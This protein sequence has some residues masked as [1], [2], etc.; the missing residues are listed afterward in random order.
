VFTYLLVNLLSVFIPFVASFD[1]RLRFDREWRYFI[2]AMLLTLAF[3]IVWD[4]WFT[5]MG[6]WGFNPVYL[7]GI[8]LINL[9]IEEWMFFIAIPYACVFTYHALKY[10]I[11]KDVLGKAAP[12]IT[13]A[14]N[15]ALAAVL[16]FAPLKWYTSLTFLLTM[17]ALLIVLWRREVWLGRF[18]LHFFIILIPFF[19]VNGILTGSW[20]SDQVVWYNDAENLGFRLGTIPVEDSVYALLLLLMNVGFYEYFKAQKIAWFSKKPQLGDRLPDS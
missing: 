18:Y 4:V 1:R 16:V 2:P 12:W 15:I 19:I 3:F 11:K 7:T 20:I 6:V 17:I 9:P 10:L 5:A 8:D 14:L 13:L